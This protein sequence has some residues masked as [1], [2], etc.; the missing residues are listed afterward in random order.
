M[1]FSGALMAPE[2][3]SAT[4]TGYLDSD[5][6]FRGLAQGFKEA[7]K[8]SGIDACAGGGRWI[9]YDMA[10]LADSGEYTDG[11]VGPYSSYYTSLLVP[12]DK[13]HNVVD[14]DHT[15][16]NAAS[17]RTHLCLDPCWYRDPG[18]GPDLEA[19]RK[20]WEIYHYLVAQGVAGRWSHV[21]RPAV[22]NDDAVWYFQRMDR[23]KLQ[24]RHHR[25]ARQARSHVLPHLQAEG[26]HGVRLLLRRAWDYVQA[27]DDR[28]GARGYRN[29]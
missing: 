12:P 6:N 26:A 4:D 11:G 19:I 28:S 21:F 23:T 14:F 10:R 18:D 24:G 15:F 25:Q 5:Q 2:G 29:L 1:I 8:A 27:D 17:D 20:D 7:H 13:Y 22:E 16:Y 9:S 3:T